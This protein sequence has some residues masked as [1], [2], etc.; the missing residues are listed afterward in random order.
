[1]LG[2]AAHTLSTGGTRGSCIYTDIPTGNYT[3]LAAERAVRERHFEVLSACRVQLKA[4][5]IPKELLLLLSRTSQASVVVN[6]ALDIHLSPVCLLY[7]SPS[8]RD[9]G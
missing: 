5:A 3:H 2:C 4:G 7:T 9:R 1:M 8:P 6:Q